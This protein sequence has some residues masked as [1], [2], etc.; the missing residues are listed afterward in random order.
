MSHSSFCTTCPNAQYR[1]AKRLNFACRRFFATLVWLVIAFTFCPAQAGTIAYYRAWIPTESLT[2]LLL[3]PGDNA[4]FSFGVE[5]LSNVPGTANLLVAMNG[6]A[7]VRA[8]YIIVSTSPSNCADPS[9]DGYESFGILS[10]GVRLL[11]PGEQQVC[12]Y[13]ITRLPGSRSDL[14][15]GACGFFGTTVNPFSCAY[16]LKTKRGTWVAGTLPDVALRAVPT[17]A[18][19]N[20]ALEATLRIIATNPGDREV[21]AKG[22]E[23]V[24]AEFG[25]GI[26]GP[27]PFNIDNDFPGAC[28]TAPGQAGCGNFTGQHFSS[29]AFSMGPIPAS[30]EASCLLHLRFLNPLIAPVALG[31][32]FQSDTLP[33][34]DGA[35]GIDPNPANEL[36]SLTAGPQAIEVPTAQWFALLAL[37]LGLLLAAS[38][39]LRRRANSSH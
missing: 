6:S 14:N 37:G 32:S 26:F 35:F 39:V 12:S 15:L 33:F 7:S 13:R 4:E 1:S 24:C 20:G 22:M 36:T 16:F 9:I 2:E 29:K 27:S 31:F 18:I 30:G 21:L 19:P 38:V 34:S 3:Q 10:F 23:T 11:Q 28:P 25:G 17:A 8:G 5:N